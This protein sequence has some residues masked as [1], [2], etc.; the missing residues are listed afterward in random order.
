MDG[1]NINQEEG[2]I[3]PWVVVLLLWADGKLILVKD[4]HGRYVLPRKEGGAL[5]KDLEFSYEETVKKILTEHKIEYEEIKELKL[6]GSKRIYYPEELDKVFIKAKIVNGKILSPW[7]HAG[8]YLPTDISLFPS[9]DEDKK[10]VH[11]FFN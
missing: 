2:K 11:D 5:A 1:K 7:S 4:S 3:F 8:F 10:I 9:R 6:L